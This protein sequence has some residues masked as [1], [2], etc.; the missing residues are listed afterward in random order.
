MRFW[1]GAS[2]EHAKH[3]TTTG[4]PGA[5]YSC[6]RESQSTQ[7]QGSKSGGQVQMPP[8]IWLQV[9]CT[10]RA[11]SETCSLDRS[12]QKILKDQLI[13]HHHYRYSPGLLT[14]GR[15]LAYPRIPSQAAVAM[16]LPDAAEVRKEVVGFPTS[17]S[18]PLVTQG[19]NTPLS[20]EASPRSE[21]GCS[22]L[23]DA[24]RSGRRP[25]HS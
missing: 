2:D 15:G 21:A 4:G 9:L 23:H 25:G 10:R 24:D 17:F 6:S 12:T 18:S 13:N 5:G 11:K 8:F 19:L 14:H 16:A 20:R 22:S 1:D 3:S 7:G